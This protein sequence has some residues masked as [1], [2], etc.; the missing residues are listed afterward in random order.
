MRFSFGVFGP[1]C[2]S[3]RIPWSLIAISVSNS[4][5]TKRVFTPGRRR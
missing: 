4:A 3:S 5:V 1:M 2:A